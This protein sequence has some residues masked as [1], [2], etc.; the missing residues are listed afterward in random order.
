[1]SE[2][3]PLPEESYRILGACFEVYN[4]MGCGFLEPV[5]QECLEVELGFQSIPFESQPALNLEYKGRPL[6][7]RYQPDFICFG[8]VLVEIKAVSHLGSEHRA[9]TLN[10]LN[11]SGFQVALLVNFGH[12]PKLDYERIVN[13]GHGKLRTPCDDKKKEDWASSKNQNAEVSMDDPT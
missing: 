5:Y 8:R 6:Q 10:Y 12:F 13:Q 7:K 1:M 2:E 3:F 9:Q 4:E 11:A